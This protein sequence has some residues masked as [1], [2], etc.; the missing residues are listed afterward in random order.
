MILLLAL[1]CEPDLEAQPILHF[2][3]ETCDGCGMLVSEPAYA[4][5][6]VTRAGET[7]AFDDPGCLFRY[8]VEHVPSVAHLWFSDGEHWYNESEVRFSGNAVTP[9]G[10]GLA[11]VP[12][13]TVGSMS[14]GQA[15][16][17]VLSR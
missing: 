9:M 11:V 7:F 4:A 5:A 13:G 17:H 15:S 8:V 10:S 1:S 16:A 2:D 6:I 12:V 3:H 14:V